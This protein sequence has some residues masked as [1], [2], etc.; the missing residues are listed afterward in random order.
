[1]DRP[2]SAILAA[3]TTTLERMMSDSKDALSGALFVG[4]H[5]HVSCIDK[6]TGTEVWRTSLPGSGY[7]FVNVLLEDGRVY[8]G[9][10]GKLYCL[11]ADNGEIL[12]TNK[13][14]GLGFG[15]FGFATVQ[16]PH[17]GVGPEAASQETSN[18]TS[19]GTTH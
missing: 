3:V 6:E 10:G 7:H 2:R 16:S 9:S 5:G 4:A 15:I 11:C 19:N 13:M 1:M 14:K 12:W 17:G 18:Q 8:A